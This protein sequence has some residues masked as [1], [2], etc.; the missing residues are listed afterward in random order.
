LRQIAQEYQL[1]LDRVV[2]V[3]HSAGGHLALWAASRKRLPPLSALYVRDPLPIRG[4]VD[5]AGPGDMATEIAVE[6][7]AC[8]SRVVEQFL[9]GSPADVPERYAQ[10]SAS[11]MLPL[12]VPQVLV[13]GDHDNLRPVWLGKK[14][15]EAATAAGDT[16]DLIIVPGLGH[17]EV[18]SPFSPAWPK[19][20]DAIRFLLQSR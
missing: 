10:V 9:G 20:R 13:W 18:A 5:W 7:G 12:G 3:G 17:F 8:Q 14:Y 2:I 11:K 16:V 15:T 1:D 19:V 4:V 6:V